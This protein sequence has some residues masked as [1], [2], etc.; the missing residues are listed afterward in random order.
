MRSA[1]AP[2]KTKRSPANGSA[3]EALLDLQG[4]TFHALTHIRP[5][6]RKPDPSPRGNRNHRLTQRPDERPKLMRCREHGGMP[7][8]LFQY[9]KMHP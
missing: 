7:R 6:H 3:A 2:L 1:L 4:Q 8:Q 9:P 5:A